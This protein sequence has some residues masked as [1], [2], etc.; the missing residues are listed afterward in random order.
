MANQSG[1]RTGSGS[2]FG[3][4]EKN[5]AQETAQSTMDK[6]RDTATG[7]MD[8][9]KE[10]ASSAT[11]SAKDITSSATQSAKDMASSTGERLEGVSSSVGSGMRSLGETIR[12]RAPREG[13]L[14]S[15]AASLAG[16]MEAGGRYLEEE[17]FSGM[18]S[19]VTSLIRRNPIPAL[20]LGVG[21]G[22]LLATAAFSSRSHHHRY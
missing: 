21:L 18:M 1:S 8:K 11:Q 19:D 7:V 5:K 16:S 12:E 13:M 17:G 3:S 9:A 2:Q 6:A 10:M 14:G 15:G 20:L 4:E 22:C